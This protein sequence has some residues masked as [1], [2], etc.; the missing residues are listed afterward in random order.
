MLNNV[1]I[2]VDFNLKYYAGIAGILTSVEETLFL[3]CLCDL[4]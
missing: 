4:T 1:A 2:M 3:S